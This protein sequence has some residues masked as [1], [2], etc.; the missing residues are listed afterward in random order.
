[1]MRRLDV[2][3]VMD[4]AVGYSLNM[5]YHSVIVRFLWCG[6]VGALDIAALVG[7]LPQTLV[8]CYSEYT[9][10]LWMAVHHSRMTDDV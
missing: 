9:V 2:I 7:C 8:D 10:I 3:Y 5:R 1:M 4:T 6:V